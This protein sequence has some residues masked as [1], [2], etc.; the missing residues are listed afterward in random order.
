MDERYETVTY[1][2]TA[3]QDERG[4]IVNIFQ[5]E[6]HHVAV[7]TRAKGSVFA[8]HWHPGEN[9]QRM[10]LMSG[11]YR[12]RS[13]PLDK[14]G[15][16]IGEVQDLVVHAGG[17]TETGP[18]IGHAYEAIEDCV[19]LNLNSNRRDP[20]GFGEHTIPLDTPLIPFPGSDPR[21]A[22]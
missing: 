3:F 6:L 19:F 5:G 16:P 4:A 15:K 20:G 1:P 14:D 11:S 7:I 9:V 8:N 18:Y 17:L 2:E 12:V 22:A 10:F 21:E 13:V